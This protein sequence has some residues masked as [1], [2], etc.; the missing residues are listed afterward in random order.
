MNKQMFFGFVIIAVAAL[1][2]TS[3]MPEA[4][5]DDIECIKGIKDKFDE[6]DGLVQA[7]IIVSKQSFFNICVLDTANI[8]GNIIVEENAAVFIYDGTT[9]DGN[10]ELKG[11]FSSVNF[12]GQDGIINTLDGNLFGEQDTYAFLDSVTVTTNVI[13]KGEVYVNG[14]PDS[15]NPDNAVE[16]DR[17]GGPV[18]IDGNVDVMTGDNN[19]FELIS[20]TVDGNVFVDAQVAVQIFDANIGGNLVIK[21]SENTSPNP[22]PSANNPFIKIEFT[23]I[24]GNLQLDKNNMLSILINDNTIGGNLGLKENSDISMNNNTIEQNANCGKNASVTGIGNVI[25]GKG[26]KQCKNILPP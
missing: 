21:E 26:Q 3:Q 2:L 17:T 16:F 15:G 11:K 6:T 4:F 14:T 5:A 19:E 9:I 8:K 25:N 1:M 24:G 22:P 12:E 23:D 10:V 13:S 7:N 18:T 20:A